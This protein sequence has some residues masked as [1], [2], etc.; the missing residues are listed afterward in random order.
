MP[1]ANTLG[2]A[3]FSKQVQAEDRSILLH[4]FTKNMLLGSELYSVYGNSMLLFSVKH[5]KL[6]LCFDS[7]GHDITNAILEQKLSAFF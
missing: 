2:A 3:D 4:Y 1:Q 7:F 6:H 5:M